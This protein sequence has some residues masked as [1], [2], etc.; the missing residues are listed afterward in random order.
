[1]GRLGGNLQG[2]FLAGKRHANGTASP[3]SID[4]LIQDALCLRLIR[5]IGAVTVFRIG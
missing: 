2:E 4:I 3:A 5:D 1:M